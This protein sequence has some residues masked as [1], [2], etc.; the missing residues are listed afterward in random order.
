MKARLLLL[1]LLPAALWLAGQPVLAAPQ[2]QPWRIGVAGGYSNGFWGMLGREGLPRE[3]MI[4]NRVGDLAYLKQFDVVMLTMPAVGAAAVSAAVE[5]F[6]KEGGIAVT[7]GAVWPSEEALPGRRITQRKGPNFQFLEGTSPAARGLGR[8]GRLPTTRRPASSIIPV[9]GHPDTYILAR[10]TDE[11]ANDDTLGVFLDGDKG[12]PGLILFRYGQGWWLWSGTWTGY[13]TAL[14]GPHFVPAILNTLELG[15]NW[16]LRSRWDKRPLAPESL[17][18]SRAALAET[19]PRQPGPG[20][21]A[22]PGEGYE[23]LDDS[24][25]LGGDFDLAGTWSAG[26]SATV[27]SSYWNPQ[28]QRRVEFAQGT[29]R[30]VAAVAGQE[31]TLGSTAPGE[32]DAAADHEL[33]VRR[34]NGDVLV[35]VDG[36]PVLCVVDGPPMQG[37]VAS[38]GLAEA[39]CQPAGPTEFADEFMRSNEE[40]SDWTPVSGNWKVQQEVG[41]RGQGQVAQSVNP[42]RYEATAEA[43]AP[44][45]STAGMWFWDDYQAEVRARPNCAGVG[46][47]AHYADEDNHLAFSISFP[48]E[49]NGPAQARLVCRSGGQEQVLATG[50]CAAARGQWVKPALRVSGGYVQGLVDD[51][52]VLRAS[53]PVRGT[54]GIGLLVQDG[55]ALFDDVLVTPWVAM[56][57]SC[58]GPS[59]SNW[60]TEEGALAKADK[61]A[62]RLALTASPSARALSGWEG[63]PAYECR[64]T[65]ALGTAAEAGLLMRYLGPQAWYRVGLAQEEAGTLGVSLVRRERDAE[66]VLARMSLPGTRDTEIEVRARLADAHLRVWVNGAT[67]FDGMDEGPRAGSVGLWARDGQAVFGAVGALPVEREE[68]LVDDLTP[69]F[70]GIIDRAT[71]AG[72]ANFLLADPDDLELMWHTGEFISDVTAKVGVRQQPEEPVTV[73]SLVLGDGADP[74]SGYEARIARTWDQEGTEL[75]LLRKGEAAAVASVALPTTRDSF[76]AEFARINGALALRIDGQTALVHTDPARLDVRRVGIRLVGSLL[77]PDDTRIETA[78]VR[79]YTFGQAPTD[80]ITECGTWEVASRWSCSPGW[81]WF[82]GWDFKDA[83]CTN[84]E[85]F[86]GDQRLDVFVGAKMVD[87]PDGKKQEVLRDIRLGLCTTPGDINS[88]YRF[89]LGGKGNTWTAILRDG[90][91]LA[92]TAWGMPQGGLHNDWALVS[93]ARRGNLLT[94]S[95]EGHEILRAEDPSPLEQGH[96][97]IGTFDNGIMVPKMTIFGQLGERKPLEAN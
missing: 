45:L 30:V 78:N 58:A 75:T 22:A 16:E 79:V 62:D 76:E 18:T 92:E 29:V 77:H 47:V 49:G 46:I 55:Q 70:A 96:A 7:E 86:L 71:W 72:K 28:W 93:A 63:G 40:D 27:L 26:T 15:S 24:L 74:D 37:V 21:P 94:V 81:T 33:H 64:G 32:I 2:T 39:I 67:L 31:T 53:D 5:Q 12:A 57:V 88:G 17:L 52:V 51:V 3:R 14:S 36:R 48:A 54:G 38:S 10:F 19:A 50:L 90:K 43:G 11:G 34:R 91:V 13:W 59:P 20:E 6:V 73:V 35:R 23:I 95:W 66:K 82:A 80:W 87:L 56:P 41:D 61:I 42:F 68:Q 60:I 1:A 25:E 4:E 89:V 97:A 83:W 9:E 65:L 44:A 84:K 85:V 8:G 69:S